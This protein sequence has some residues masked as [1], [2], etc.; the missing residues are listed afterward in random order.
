MERTLVRKFLV[1]IFFAALPAFAQFTTVTG[2]VIDPNGVPYA[3]GTIT[4]TLVIPSGAGSPTLN[5][6]PYTPPTQATGLDQTGSFTLNVADNT[7]LQPGGTKWNFLVCSAAGTVNPA[8]G[9]G[10]VCFTLAIPITISGPSQSITSQ[11]HSAA[12]ALTVPIGGGGGGSPAAPIGSVQTNLNGTAFGSVSSVASGSALVSQGTGVAPVY[13]PKL[14]YDLRDQGFVCDGTTY[15]TSAASQLVATIAGNYAAVQ[16]P[17]GTICAM[18]DFVWPNNILLDFSSGWQL[19]T[20]TDNTTT[21]GNAQF[22]TTAGAAGHCESN[23]TTTTCAMS[24]T[25]PANDTYVIACMRGF[26]SGTPSFTSSVA[27]DVVI[28]L[29]GSST[30]FV[31]I[32]A[33]ALIPTVTAGAHTFT[34]TFPAN[35]V[36]ACSAIPISGLGPTPYLDGAGA[37]T[38]NGSANSPMSAG[39]ATFQSGSFLL[40]WGGN[41]NTAET[42]TA[43][44]GFTQPAGNVGNSTN[45]NSV[46]CTEYKNSSAAGSTTATQSFVPSPAGHFWSYQLIGLR[47]SSAINVVL[48]GISNPLNRQIFVNATGTAGLIDFTG[49]L[50]P[51][52]VYPEWWGAGYGASDSTNLAALQA[53][54]KGAYGTNRT[55]GTGLQQYNKVWHWA[56]PYKINGEL[57]LYHV[58][59][60]GPGSRAQLWCDPGAG[61]TQDASNQRIFDMQSVAYWDFH[62]CNFQT[63]ASQ[64]A[65][66]PLIDDD[67]NGVTTAGDLAP[68]FTTGYNIT[69]NGNNIAAIGLL[70]AKSGGGAQYSNEYCLDCAFLNFTQ[71]CYQI[72]TPTA[73]AQNALAIGFSGDMQSCPGYGLVTYGG[74]YV[75][76]SAGSNG[77][78]SMENGF[79]TQTGFD[80]AG[81]QMQ[82]PCIMEHM[83]SESR[84]LISCP[85]VQIKDSRTINQ[86]ATMVPGQSD[87][88]GF[89]MRGDAIIGDGAYHVVTVDASPFAGVGTII[90]PLQASSGTS[91]SLT[92]TNQTVAGSVTIGSIGVTATE[93]MTQAV[94]GATGTRLN[95][96]ANNATIAG[97]LTSGSF[98]FGDTAQQ[99][100]TGVTCTIGSGNTGT[101]FNC[102][103]FSGTADNSHTWTDLTT[104]GTFNPSATP[105]FA[106]ASPTML[107]TAATGAPDSTHDWV[108]GTTGLHYTPTAAPV[109][110]AN[111]TVNAFTGL[112]MGIPTGTSALCFG[113]VTSNTAQ[114]ITFSGG[115][116][117]KY[118]NVVCTPPDST[119]TFYVACPQTH[120]TDICGGIAMQYVNE[121]VISGDLSADTGASGTIEDVFAPGGQV[122]LSGNPQAA[123]RIKNLTVSRSDWFNA[124][125]GNTPQNG[126]PIRDWNVIALLPS[127]TTPISWSFP[128]LTGTPVNTALHD[129][130]GAKMLC[131]NTGTI[132]L[133]T[134]LPANTSA[135]EI[136]AGGRSYNGLGLDNF[137]QRFEVNGG[138]GVNPGIGPGTPTGVDQNGKDFPVM[139]GASTG[140]GNPGGIVFQIGQTGSTGQ[141]PNTGSTIWAIP[142]SGANAKNFIAQSDNTQNIGANGANRPANGYFANFVSSKRLNVDQATTL[143][144]GD[145]T[146]GAG[147]GSTAATAITVATSKDQASVTTITTGG[148]GI[149]INP[150]YQI[151]FHD[152]TWTQTPVCTARQTGGN[153]IVAQFTVTARSATSY[154]FQWNGTPTTGKTY[155]V[156]IDCTGT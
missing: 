47:P 80:M 133:N 94:T 100:T 35:L 12:L 147:W 119:S 146:L 111:F 121:N 150:T 115:L 20:P 46:L 149:A 92:D 96:P 83:R 10:S 91:T 148:S 27:S 99:A 108:G 73:L 49:N 45:T 30:T 2:T 34:A 53:S 136:C 37:I 145:F 15:N 4:P 95:S 22:D 75:S 36:G 79:A 64:D 58:L 81:S 28:P 6:G 48:G 62:N 77:I 63:A 89:Y 134:P 107:I 44:A 113:T 103:N 72:G 125:N 3:G 144:T 9:K 23:N 85:S 17:S 8:I 156:T 41:N 5:G 102:S 105:V 106:P 14:F 1:L 139:G 21:P 120:G 135:N 50:T 127:G 82:G 68:Q 56:Q 138:P 90:S 104:L 116:S 78:S 67:F 66:H 71:A 87:P 142:G 123:T 155:E 7:V 131:W 86:A 39:P 117:T 93:L 88:V 65:T 18:G 128:A 61:I 13:Q 132:G 137:I 31:S 141:V 42:C 51:F 40:A 54:E 110:Q 124:A 70:A 52:H 152:G 33:G 32:T 112:L 55:N 57:Q 143:V 74:G 84:R 59:G 129:D 154:T 101:V 151:T 24:V 122:H 69:L 130:L 26:S 109:N 126:F 19:K 25:A 11:L 153:D 97:T 98:V 114:S 140:A 76:V 118:P 43:G 38:S 60:V 16:A 29:P